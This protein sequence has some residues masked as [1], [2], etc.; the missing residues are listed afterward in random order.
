VFKIDQVISGAQEYVRFKLREGE[1]AVWTTVEDQLRLLR[2]S[3]VSGPTSSFLTCK[4]NATELAPSIQLVFGRTPSTFEEYSENVTI[5]LATA[6]STKQHNFKLVLSN[7][8]D[9]VKRASGFP[10]RG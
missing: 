4:A 2:V 5:N 8:G 10:S 7:V 6:D 3:L 9:S 1:L